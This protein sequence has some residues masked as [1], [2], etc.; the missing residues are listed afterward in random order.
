MTLRTYLDSLL[1]RGRVYFTKTEALGALSLSLASLMV[2][3]HRLKAKGDIISPARGLYVIIPPEEKMVGCI[4][5]EELV[6]I[7]MA[8]WKKDYYVGMLSAALYQGSSHQKPQVFQ[9]VTDTQIKPVHCGH[10]KIQ[11]IYKKNIQD[12]PTQF[13]TVKTGYLKVGMPELT[14]YDLL[15]YHRQAG[16][17]NNIATVLGELIENIEISR[18]KRFAQKKGEVAWIQRLCFILESIDTFEEA[19]KTQ[20]IKMLREYIETRKIY[21]VPLLRGVPF[22]GCKRNNTWK[23]IENT[24]IESDL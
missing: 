20:L 14:V 21:P 22:K 13:V 10:V 3:I 18:L 24:V 8:Y 15:H 19:K 9:V 1:Q 4:P 2:S 12:L 16:G 6:P 5:A 17:L 7:L 11:F 23:I